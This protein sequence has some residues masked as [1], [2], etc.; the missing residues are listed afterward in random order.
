MKN[1]LILSIFFSMFGLSAI[2]DPITSATD[3]VTGVTYITHEESV[4]Q[5][6]G[7]SIDANGNYLEGS[8]IDPLNPDSASIDIIAG[9]SIP[10]ETIITTP[11]TDSIGD[12]TAGSSIPIDTTTTPT[13]DTTSDI[14]TGASTT[15]SGDDEEDE[16]EDHD[17]DEEDERDDYY[18]EHEDDDYEF[19]D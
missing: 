13:T 6:A 10:I 1:K 19:D 7:A 16:F 11:L 8:T 14:T 3:M 18:F 17:E 9:S 12:L 2:I 5:I 15:Y 4:D